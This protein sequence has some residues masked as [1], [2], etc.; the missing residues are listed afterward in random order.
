MQQG[1]MMAE[2]GKGTRI[3]P[4]SVFIVPKCIRMHKYGAKCVV[5]RGLC[6]RTS[7]MAGQGWLSQ[8][9]F[10]RAWG[11]FAPWALRSTSDYGFPL[12]KS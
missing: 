1:E 4:L 6:L 3:I 7:L 10:D 9:S 8:L 11:C 12:Q 5:F 2:E